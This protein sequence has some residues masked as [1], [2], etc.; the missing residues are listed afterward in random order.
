[1]NPSPYSSSAIKYGI[2]N[3]LTGKVASGSF[4]LLNLLILVR[5]MTIGDY[6]AYVTIFA[7]LELTW[8]FSGLGLPW[9]AARYVP[10]FRIHASGYD[11][12]I[13]AWKLTCISAVSLIAAAVLAL[14]MSDI[15]ISILELSFKEKATFYF[16]LVIF[17]EGMGQFFVKAYSV[18]Y[19]FSGKFKSVS[20]YVSL[21][22]LSNC[23][24][25]Y[26]KRRKINIRR[27]G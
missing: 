21:H 9:V 16:V 24:Y 19:C 2:W 6:G 13:F 12:K 11:L 1:M 26:F 8:A 22:F 5:I 17:F 23:R 15:Y 20:L 18:L 7:G 27:Y 25:Y 4:T 14:L 3:F 10:D